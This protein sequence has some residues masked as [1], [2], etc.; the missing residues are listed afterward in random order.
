MR[1][2]YRI[3]GLGGEANEETV[4]SLIDEEVEKCLELSKG[5]IEKV[6]TLKK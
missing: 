6:V 5:L 1:I 3:R 2:V 4:D